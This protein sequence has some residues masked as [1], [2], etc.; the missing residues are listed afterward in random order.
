MQKSMWSSFFHDL[1]PE[2]AVELFAREGWTRLELSNEHGSALL[3]R[4]DA[5][6][7]GA[8]FQ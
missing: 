7:T 2:E 6:R 5:E 8:A 1:P 4:G 3:G